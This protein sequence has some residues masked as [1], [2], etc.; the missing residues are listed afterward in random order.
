[1]IPVGTLLGGILVQVVD[2]NASRDTALRAPFVVAAVIF[3][4]LLIYIVPRLNSAVIDE[5]KR[6]GIPA[7]EAAD[8]AG[9][10]S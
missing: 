2:S 5:A 10:Q 3:V 9:E 8:A 6:V 7:K 4:F 1:M